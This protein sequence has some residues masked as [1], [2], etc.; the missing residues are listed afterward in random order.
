LFGLADESKLLDWQPGARYYPLGIRELPE[1]SLQDRGNLATLMILLER[2]PSSGAELEALYKAFTVWFRKHPDH[3]RLRL[4]LESM[5]RRAFREVRN[6]STIRIDFTGMHE[7]PETMGQKWERTAEARGVAKGEVKG[8]IKGKAELVL[9]QMRH[10]FGDLPSEIE[11]V[12][13]SASE[14]QLDEW[15]LRVLSASTPDEVLDTQH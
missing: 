2:R 9:N 15:C 10:K 1:A 14:Q 7:M 12:V 6:S 13:E 4:V 5:M 8:K 11:A 3:D